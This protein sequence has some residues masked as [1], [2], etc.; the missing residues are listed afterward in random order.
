MSISFCLASAAAVKSPLPIASNA[1]L[2][3]RRWAFKNRWGS[4]SRIAVWPIMPLAAN[5]NADIGGISIAALAALRSP[6]WRSRSTAKNGATSR[7]LRR[8]ARSSEANTFS[9]WVL[10][11]AIL[12]SSAIVPSVIMSPWRSRI[13]R[14]ASALMYSLRGF[15][16]TNASTIASGVA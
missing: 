7:C 13:T 5:R 9:R 2:P 8:N 6:A 15:M 12:A 3:S 14:S 4:R 10:C 16:P 1:F 11:R